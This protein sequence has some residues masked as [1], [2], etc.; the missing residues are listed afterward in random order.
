MTER[1]WGILRVSNEPGRLDLLKQ[2]L[3]EGHSVIA[4]RA[5]DDDVDEHVIEGPDMP[6]VEDG[7]PIERT[8][9][10][11]QV[12]EDGTYCYWCHAMHKRWRVA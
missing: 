8:D 1:H 7:K 9:I 10:M 11:T 5:L 12:T 2:N 3:P 6:L 4:T